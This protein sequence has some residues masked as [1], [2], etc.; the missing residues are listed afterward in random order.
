MEAPSFIIGQAELA[1]RK[2][3]DTLYP[4]MTQLTLLGS[5]P[6]A[7]GRSGASEAPFEWLGGGRF[8]FLFRATWSSAAP[9]AIDQGEEAGS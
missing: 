3:S 1:R 4:F 5:R 9:P 2:Q 6:A 7:P 8:A